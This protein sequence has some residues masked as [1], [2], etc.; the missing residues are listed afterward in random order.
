M[1]EI[2]KIHCPICTQPISSSQQN[3]LP[4]AL[5]TSVQRGENEVLAYSIHKHNLVYRLSQAILMFLVAPGPRDLFVASNLWIL[6][7]RVS[8]SWPSPK[9][10]S[11]KEKFQTWKFFGAS[12]SQ[13]I[14]VISICPTPKKDHL[15][16]NVASDQ[17]II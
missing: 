7:R 11:T 5:A 2:E 16:M 17:T 1:A 3:G 15:S 14:W 4:P 9:V 8:H 13:A 12:L 10:S 6:L